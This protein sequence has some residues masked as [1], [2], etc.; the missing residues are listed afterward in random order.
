VTDSSAC[1]SAEIAAL[2]RITVVSLTV[3][4]DGEQ[5]RDEAI[6]GRE[7]YDRLRLSQ[8]AMSAAP[9][10]GEFSEAFHGARQS[11]A[12]AVLCLTLPSEYSGTYGAAVNARELV[13]RE[14]P[15]F[16]VR[17]VDTRCMAMA[18]GFCVLAAARAACGG[19]TLDETVAAAESVAKRTHLVGALETTRY[20]AKSGRVPWIVHWAASLLRIKPVIAA[21]EGR[22]GAVGRART[23]G[24][25]IEKMLRYLEERTK[26]GAVLHVGVMHADAAEGA[27]EL[28]EA[29]RKRFS[30]VELLVTD[31][32]SAMGVHTGPGFL[33]LAFYWDD[34]E[35]G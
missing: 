14:W 15:D 33:G 35:A 32:T 26:P 24:S 7:F 9:A 30:P 29:V 16:P 25:A 17:V 8:E 13:S 20:L 6:T 31:V 21:S 19:A 3:A 12:D 27:S 4:I 1:L 34:G 22:I 11:G 2:H 23:I 5:W 10:P 28:A 18:H